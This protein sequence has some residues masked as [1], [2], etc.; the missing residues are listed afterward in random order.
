MSALLASAVLA[1]ATA[2]VA[3]A[4]AQGAPGLDLPA[5]IDF[6]TTA[7]NHPVPRTLQVGVTGDTAISFGTTL[8]QTPNTTPTAFGEFP[9]REDGCAG[10]TLQPGATCSLTVG[11][12]PYS[13]GTRTGTLL[14]KDEAGT[15]IGT[16]ALSGVATENAEGTFYPSGPVR[17]LDT[18]KN[19]ARTPLAG[20]STTTVALAGRAGIP[21]TGVSAVVVNLT[22]VATTSP[23]Y[24]TAYPSDRKRPTA[25][26]INFPKGWTGAIMAT[27]PVGADGAIRLYNYGGPAHA[28]VDVLGWYAADPSVL[29][30][31]GMGTML[32]DF[33]PAERIFDSR[34]QGGALA[35][36]EAVE[37]G[38]DWGTTDDNGAVKSWVL[39]VTA[40]GATRPGVV[41]AWSGQGTRPTVSTVNYEP[42]V[43]AP[44]MAVVTSGHDAAGTFFRLENTSS[45]SVHLVVDVVGVMLAGQQTG[46]RFV[47]LDTPTRFLDTR[48][49]VGLTG[50]FGSHSTRVLDTTSVTPAP[51]DPN[52]VSHVVGTTTGV[53]PANRTYVSAWGHG[54]ARPMTSILNVEKGAVRS[55]ATYLQ[56]DVHNRADVYN[57][58]GPAHLVMDAVGVFYAYD[59]VNGGPDIWPAPTRGA[60]RSGFVPSDLPKRFASLPESVTITR[61]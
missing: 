40:V 16:V 30:A 10:R 49:G 46:L 15:T 41:T 17:L 24:F 36:K 23:G 31:N 27:V 35:G 25:S 26:T 38:V 2:L 47:R 56:V 11:F 7:M 21:T 12:K 51:I 53:K 58:A 14:L 61:R 42:G 20:G 37:L 33:Q 18:R 52:W 22:A 28:L 48:T 43:I 1:T 54:G 59:E 29:A 45:G 13:T 39:N 9:V 55:N 3:P 50:A 5:S 32:Y 8:A 34:S 57:D 44:N 60:V 6:G 4:A 19:G